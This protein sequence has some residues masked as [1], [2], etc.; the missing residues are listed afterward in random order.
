MS[1]L[2]FLLLASALPDTVETPADTAQTWANGPTETLPSNTEGA[3]VTLYTDSYA[4]LED[5]TRQIGYS[6]TFP[7]TVS[8]IKAMITLSG[9]VQV[10][11]ATKEYRH[12][13]MR[14]TDEKGVT[15]PA[16][17]RY[18]PDRWEEFTD[19]HDDKAMYKRM[20]GTDLPPS[21]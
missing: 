2:L 8:Q 10:K 6:A 11:C 15:R 19:N 5:G 18:A 9:L 17:Q 1:L 3:Q 12:I 7:H 14:Y 20:C 4:E 21:D 16:P 13:H